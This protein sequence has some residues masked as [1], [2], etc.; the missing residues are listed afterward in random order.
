MNSHFFMIF[1]KNVNLGFEMKIL[2]LS[3]N[4]TIKTEVSGSIIR[5][6]WP[7]NKTVNLSKM[8]IWWYKKPPVKHDSVPVWLNTDHPNVRVVTHKDIFPNPDHLPT[9][10]S[11]AIE[12]N[13]HRIPG[14][15]NRFIYSNDDLFLMRPICPG[16]FGNSVSDWL[17]P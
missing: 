4:L 2:I 1:P 6:V 17:P 9:F 3:R 5:L 16:K 12:I 10:S 15:S 11:P 8:S 7:K 14:L 13:M